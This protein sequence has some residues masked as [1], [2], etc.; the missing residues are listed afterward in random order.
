MPAPRSLFDLRCLAHYQ[1]GPL[2]CSRGFEMEYSKNWGKRQITPMSTSMVATVAS[3]Q[4][5]M[6]A[7]AATA[8]EIDHAFPGITRL[9]SAAEFDSALPAVLI[10]DHP[11]LFHPK[12]RAAVEQDRVRV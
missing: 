11:Q 9:A 6:L 1:V 3:E 10:G 8:A 4:V 2:L 5:L 7:T 12:I